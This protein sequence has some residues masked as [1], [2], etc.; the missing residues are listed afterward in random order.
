[1]ALKAKYIPEN[2]LVGE[3]RVSFTKQ[4]FGQYPFTLW[5]DHNMST[6]QLHR[7]DVAQMIQQQEP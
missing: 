1:M 4:N 6:R 3:F 2:L 5:P 7:F